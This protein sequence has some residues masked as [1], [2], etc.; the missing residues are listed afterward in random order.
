MIKVNGDEGTR[1]AEVACRDA[2]QQL[3]RQRPQH[4]NLA[5]GAAGT[6]LCR[7]SAG[8]GL[9]NV[10]IPTEQERLSGI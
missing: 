6:R 10:A 7:P 2:E 3:R 1:E 9:P 5:S 4:S 8:S